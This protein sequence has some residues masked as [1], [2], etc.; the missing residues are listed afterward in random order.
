LRALPAAYFQ[1]AMLDFRS[2]AHKGTR[3]T[4]MLG[5]AKAMSDDEIKQTADYYAAM[6]PIA[7]NKV[8]EAATVPRTYVSDTGNR[9]LWPEPGT[10]AL[11]KR[12]IEFAPD[13]TRIRAAGALSPFVSYV[14]EGS[15]AKGQALAT[16]GAGGKTTACTLC[17]GE[18]LTGVGDIPGLA[19]RS[20]LYIARQLVL[21]QTGE[22]AGGSAALMKAVS[23]KL[24]MDDVIAVAAYAGSRDPS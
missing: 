22:R 10:E 14:P 6:K 4:S 16:T 7:W 12:I 23:A 20:P 19:G 17:H 13:P 18:T 8:V 15:L 21:Y 11:G 24:D 9:K 1:K 5:I 3:A 2:G